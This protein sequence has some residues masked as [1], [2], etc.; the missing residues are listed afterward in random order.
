MITADANS[1]LGYWCK[2]VDQMK[3]G[4]YLQAD[5]RELQDIPGFEHNG[6]HFTPADRILENIVGS[7]YTHSYDADPSGRT[8]TF[9]RH[10]ETGKRYYNSP[11]RR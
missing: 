10:E 1:K 2:R 9:K 8:V 6:A 11:D 4:E 7:S 5:M 3:P